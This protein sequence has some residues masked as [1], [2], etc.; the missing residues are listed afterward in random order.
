[1]NAQ[2]YFFMK[3]AQHSGFRGVL[4]PDNDPLPLAHLTNCIQVYPGEAGTVPGYEDVILVLCII[5]PELQ[6]DLEDIAETDDWATL[7][8][9]A[10]TGIISK[11]AG[12]DLS[13][14]H[15]WG[16]FEMHP[17]LDAKVQVGTDEET[18]KPII[19][20]VVSRIRWP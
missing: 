13:Y 2:V 20:D 6:R 18:G 16:V 9:V 15:K 12:R 3:T 19:R 4:I 8:T 1:M 14:T 11:Y 17:A 7:S 5:S 10:G